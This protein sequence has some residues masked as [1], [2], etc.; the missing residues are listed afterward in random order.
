MG[1]IGATIGLIVAGT[2]LLVLLIPVAILWVL[3]EV[4]RGFSGGGRRRER[5]DPAAE[6]LR[7]RFARGEIGQEDFEAGM[8]ALG[9]VKR[10]ES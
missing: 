9:Y 10:G 2:I 6:A 4:G 1:F 3:I 5:Y 8:R 7:Y